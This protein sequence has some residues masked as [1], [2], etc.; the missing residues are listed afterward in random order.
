ML[1]SPQNNALNIVITH[2]NRDINAVKNCLESLIAQTLFEKIKIKIFFLDYGTE[3]ILAQELKNFIENLNKKVLLP[4]GED[5]G[6]VSKKIY[7]IYHN[8]KGQFWN[9][10]HAFNLAFDFIKKNNLQENILNAEYL[11]LLD[12]DLVLEKNVLA[13]IWEIRN[14][15]Q[16]FILPFYRLPKNI[17]ANDAFSNPLEIQNSLKNTLICASGNIFFYEKWLEKVGGFDEFYRFWGM[18]DND[19]LKRLENAGSK[20]VFLENEKLPIFHQWHPVL[21]QILPKGWQTQINAYFEKTQNNISITP[22]LGVWG[23]NRITENI[24][25][26]FF[27]QNFDKNAVTDCPIIEL[28]SP[29]EKSFLEVTSAFFGLEKGKSLIFF[30]NTDFFQKTESKKNKTFFQKIIKFLNNFFQ[31]IKFS[32]RFIDVITHELGYLSP[33]QLRD[34]VFYFV[35]THEKFLE[36]YYFFQENEVF[37]LVITK[38]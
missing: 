21:S 37:C 17:L 18:E 38:K 1:N 19:F 25:L 7:Y 32:Y 6:G 14:E 5:L 15:N 22:P 24:F 3:D 34:W 36:D 27:N 28:K 33:L 30:G 12:V 11:L 2:R 8:S 10:S 16:T 4:S 13:K 31:K 26:D 23:V 9:K 29:F 35:L 20:I